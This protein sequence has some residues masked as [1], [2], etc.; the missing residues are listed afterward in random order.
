M[1]V[2]FRPVAQVIFM[3]N[4]ESSQR[5]LSPAMIEA[6]NKALGPAIEQ[7]QLAIDTLGAEKAEEISEETLA[8][9]RIL[10]RCLRKKGSPHF[11]KH[12][13]YYSLLL[14]EFS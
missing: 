11:T 7:V 1:S 13:L 4:H 8:E 2:R 5:K 14:L 6:W 3:N 12:G 10:K 9:K